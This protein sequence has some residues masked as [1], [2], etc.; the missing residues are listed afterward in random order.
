MSQTAAAVGSSQRDW[1][2]DFFDFADVTYLNLA[3]QCPIPRVSA[4][5]LE[6]AAGWK[7]LPH[8]V[9]DEAYFGV[10][11][12]IRTLLA[13]LVGG[14]PEEFALTTGASAGLMAVAQGL[15]WRAEDEILLARG[16]FPAHLSTWLPLARS[17]RLQ[18]RFVEPAGRFLTTEDVVRA[19][20]PRTRLVSVSHVRFD[21]GARVDPRPVADALH[22]RGG[23]LLLD[24]SQSAG[25]V[26]LQVRDSGA[27]FMVVSG[28]KWLLST[29]G[30]G[31]FWIKR[32]LI[33]SMQVQP[34]Y[35]MAHEQAQDFNALTSATG[36]H[37]PVRDH[38]RRWDAAETA[39]FFNL[40][41]MEASLEFVLQAGVETVWRH[42]AA[43]AG[44]LIARLPL[45]RCVLA[46]PADAALR[47]PYTCFAGRSPEKTR[48]LYERLRAAG[49]FTSL[50]GNAIRVA[51]YLYN[52]V[53][54][55]ER[56]IETLTV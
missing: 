52:T 22:Q 48:E 18:V 27:D 46:S 41:V 8:Q 32:E 19:I 25:A 13:Q 16:E 10:P 20:G 24:A 3:G 14:A 37:R 2:Q 43:L 33:E 9:P 5:A 15:P 1:S 39:S 42:N 40:A 11:D 4:K 12:H 55:I 21:D 49:I 54:D 30:T 23:Y 56:L 26:P 28:Y 6:R 51:P 29:F 7:K 31:F 45:D 35:W 17:G 50:R 47:G 44:Q 36:D 34:F 38:A 53:R